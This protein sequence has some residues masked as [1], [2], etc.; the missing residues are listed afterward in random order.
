M[1][2]GRDIIIFLAIKYEG[3]WNRIYQAIKEKE[4]VQEEEVHHAL[5]RVRSH[6]LTIID[7]DYPESLKKI[8]K[9]PFVLFYY[10]NVQLLHMGS[11]SL[12]M[13]GSRKASPYG[14]KMTQQITQALIE[15]GII[16]VSG[17]ARGIDTMAHQATLDAH[18]KT[19][20]VLGSGIDRC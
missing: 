7:D 17:L 20:A 3:D 5:A 11:R 14:L 18:G 19:I 15:E 4:H 13:I 16:V 10:G 9:P 6:V 12:A 1:M 2:K 8:Y